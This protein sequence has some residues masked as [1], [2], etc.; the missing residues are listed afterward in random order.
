MTDNT[1][2]ILAALINETPPE[3]QAGQPEPQAGPPEPEQA[4]PPPPEDTEDEAPFDVAAML[5]QTPLTE[6]E[7]AEA[8]DALAA[9]VESAV[10]PKDF[11]DRLLAADL[12]RELW[13]E[14]RSS[15]QRVALTNALRFK[16][17]LS[18]ITPVCEATA[19][20]PVRGALNYLEFERREAA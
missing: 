8:Y 7:S 17:L 20:R 12:A 16:A 13:E 4:P 3:P 14:Q 19:I 6:G 2:R 11:F 5:R 18:L 10:A 9:E 15:R 1:P